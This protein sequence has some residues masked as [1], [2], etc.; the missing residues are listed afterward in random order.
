MNCINCQK[1][2]TEWDRSY[3]DDTGMP[4]YYTEIKGKGFIERLPLCGPYCSLEYWKK[5]Q[6]NAN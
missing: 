3:L 1:V 5:K 4:K 2:Y 6:N